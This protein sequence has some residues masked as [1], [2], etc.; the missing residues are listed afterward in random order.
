MTTWADAHFLWSLDFW[1]FVPS[2]YAASSI[3]STQ[4][5]AWLPG[6]SDPAEM[7]QL[8]K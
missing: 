6:E 4:A 8:K 2:L 3:V 5:L 1:Q 7:I